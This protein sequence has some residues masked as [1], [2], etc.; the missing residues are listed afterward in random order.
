MKP[1]LPL[2]LLQILCSGFLI[3]GIPAAV[4][5]HAGHGNEFKATGSTSPAGVAVDAQIAQQMGI[6]IEAVSRQLMQTGIAA[7]GKIEALPSQ[8]VEVT[9]PIAGTLIKLLVELGDTV[10]KGD[11]VAVLSSPELAELGVDADRQR[12]EGQADTIAATAQLQ[13][14]QDNYQR[15]VTIAEAEIAEAQTQLEAAQARYDRDR[16]LVNEGGVVAAARETYQRQIEVAR[17]EISQAETELAV[18]QERYNQDRVL[19]DGGALPRRQLLES[20]SKLADAKAALTRANNRLSVMDAETAVRQAEVDLPVR[21]LR[22]SEDLL[23]QAKAQ[24]TKANQRREVGEAEAAVKTAQA[25]LQVAQ[26]RVDLSDGTYA[27]RLR[28]LGAQPNLDGTVTIAA[29]ISGTVSEQ[30]ITL[31]ESVDAAGEPLLRILDNRRVWVTASIYEKDIDRIQ[32]GQSVI[33]RVESLGK[34]TFLGQIDRISPT[35]ENTE[36]A[37]EVR[38]EL[39]NSEGELKPGM[40]AQVEVATSQSEKPVISIPS[41]ALVSANGKPVVYVQNGSKFAAVDVVLGEKFGDLVEVKLGLF[42]GDRIVTQG[43]MLLYAQSLRGGGNAEAEHEHEAEG[44]LVEKMAIPWNILFLGS[45]GVG[46]IGGVAFWLGRRSLSRSDRISS[47]QVEE[48]IIWENEVFQT[49]PIACQSTEEIAS[50]RPPD[51]SN[52]F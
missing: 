6:K 3:L 15:Q 38:A 32:E 46:A 45:M 20:E 50:D 33:V 28:Q 11:A 41:S 36:R 48:E 39:E 8:T 5:S 4:W 37:I 13:L 40:F 16:N 14:A 9:S 51:L 25:A 49:E 47:I 19:V 24:L 23:A 22:E 10:S 34:R 31:G 18:A 43:G 29:P 44:S 1:H 27:S 30:K 12:A 17:A 26:A 2:S 7:T 35:V 42:E 52:R 21:D